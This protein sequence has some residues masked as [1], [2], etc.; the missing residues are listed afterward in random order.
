MK[1]V[2]LKPPQWEVFNCQKRFR[3]LVARRRFGKTYLGAV[4]THS[5]GLG[6]R[7]SGLVCGAHTEAG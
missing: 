7:S 4:R 6:S 2:A 3:I 1:P 5:S